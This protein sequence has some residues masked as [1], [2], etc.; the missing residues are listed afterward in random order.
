ME[1][2]TFKLYEAQDRLN[3]QVTRFDEL[4]RQVDAICSAN[5]RQKGTKK[6]KEKNNGFLRTNNSGTTQSGD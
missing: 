2:P 5:I 4:C 6:I 3:K 1:H